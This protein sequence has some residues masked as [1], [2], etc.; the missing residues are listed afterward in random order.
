MILFIPYTRFTIKTYLQ[1]YEAEQQLA[2]HVEP[3]KFRWGLSRNH[4]F[5]QGTVG[6]GKFTFTRIIHYRNNFLPVVIG[7]IHDDLDTTRIEITMR[8]NYLAAALMVLLIFMLFGGFFI[9]SSMAVKDMLIFLSFLTLF[10][11]VTMAF[12]NF[13]AN[14]ARRYLKDIFQA[15][16]PD[17]I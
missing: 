16:G 3:R 12:F 7:K 9:G 17:L 13:E 10:Y 14:K 6:N 8:A 15:G 11:I 2:A 4:K 5:F 1:A